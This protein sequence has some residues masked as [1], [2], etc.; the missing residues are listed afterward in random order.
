MIRILESINDSSM[1]SQI[2]DVIDKITDSLADKIEVAY[3]D[4]T[5]LP[6]EVAI[7]IVWKEGPGLEEYIGT[8]EIN[9]NK[10]DVSN[11]SAY[12]QDIAAEI[13]DAYAYIEDYEKSL[14]NKSII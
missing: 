3:I 6:D 11:Y 7:E 13:K 12:L 14:L 2:Q 1:D 4:K 9:M 10:D 8:W 5:M